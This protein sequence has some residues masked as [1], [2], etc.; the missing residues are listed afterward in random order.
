MIVGL[1]HPS[2]TFRAWRPGFTTILLTVLTL[3]IAMSVLA[4]VVTLFQASLAAKNGTYSLD[5]WRLVL[6]NPT[7][8]DA[9]HNTI[10]LTI[11]HQLISLPIAVAVS[12]L[13]GRTDMPGRDWLEFGFWTAFFLPSL[14]VLQGWI[15]LLAPQYGLINTALAWALNLKQGPFNIYTWSGIVFA[16]LMTTAIAAKVMLMTPAFR[17]MDASLEEAAW[18]T[19]E[20]PST[21]LWKLVV[22][23]M[24][25]AIA[26]TTVMGLI[27]ALE[28]FEIE[29]VLGSPSRIY[30]YSTL[31]YREMRSYSPN[32]ANASVLG[33]LILP[34]MALLALVPHWITRGR[35]YTT[36]V[37][38][39]Q[40]HGV[41]LGIWRWP[42]F[43]ATVL[44]VSLLTL[45]PLTLLCVG[46]FMT[47]FGYFNVRPIF[48]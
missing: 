9:V 35:S 23:I 1:S 37:G 22:P 43:A 20:S 34:L 41:R 2:R 32:Y 7:L 19:G 36:I 45:I 47:L 15:L 16:H 18:M 40:L 8:I 46:S 21:T 27:R 6:S 17:N 26:V 29:L 3:V 11:A 33:L 24:A 5:Q 38:R 42:A 13:L 14:G 12:W 44:L 4:P 48:T 30:V 10:G 39:G 25:P 31:I 28:T